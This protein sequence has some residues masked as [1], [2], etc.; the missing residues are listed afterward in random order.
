MIEFGLLSS[1]FD[2]ATFGVLLFVYRAAPVQFRT[3]WFVE[4]LLTELAIAL[5][6]RTRRPFLRSRPAPFLLWSTL[7]VALVTV[8]L[9]Y[10][11]L[12][13]PLGFAALPVGLLGVIALIT[14]AYVAAA[15]W[16]KRRFQGRDHSQ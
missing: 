7:A 15:E 4:S 9:P 2:F 5:V 1:I 16:L 6:V 3:A 8:V 11:P 10:S 12:A 14:A 13:A